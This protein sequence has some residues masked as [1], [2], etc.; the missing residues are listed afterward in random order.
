MKGLL[1]IKAVSIEPN[2]IV[3]GSPR[4]QVATERTVKKES[5]S[6]ALK[7]LR[8]RGAVHLSGDGCR[9][10]WVPAVPL[11]PGHYTLLVDE[12]E[13]PKG[14]PITERFSVPFTV[15]QSQSK[16]PSNLIIEGMQRLKIGPLQ[17]TKL[18]VFERPAGRY[19]ELIKA[20]DRSSGSPRHL[21]FNE[22]GNR[23]D[24]ER[25]IMEQMQRR[26]RRYG[27]LS[28]E[29][30][31]AIKASKESVPVSIWF[32]PSSM[33]A[34]SALTALK[35]QAF[36][37]RPKQVTAMLRA[38][39]SRAATIAS[40]IRDLGGRNVLPSRLAPVVHADLAPPEI[41]RLSGMEEITGIFLRETKGIPDLDDSIEI[42][43]SDDVHDLGQKGS[44][45]RVAVW[46]EGPDNT[47]NLSIKGQFDTSASA[48]TSSHSRLVHAVI[49]NTQASAKGHAPAC[50]LYSANSY[51]NDALDWA[52]ETPECTVINQSFHRDSEQTSDSLSSDDIYKD[53]LILHWPFPTILQAA[54][55]D[56]NPGVEYVNHKGYNSLTVGNHND[57]ASSMSGTS[58]YRNPSSN[59]SD[60]ELPEISANGVGVTAVGI[61]N[62]GTSFASP[63]VAGIAALIQGTNTLLKRWPEG[64]RAILLAGAKRNIQGQTWWQDVVADVDA[65]D[66]SGSADALES[67]FI[68][69][70]RRSRNSAGTRRGWDVGTMRSGDFNDNGLSTFSYRITIPASPV[71]S[72]LGPRHV[73]VALAWNSQVKTLDELFPSWFPMPEVPIT[74]QLTLD[75]DLKVF[76]SNGNLVGYSGSWDNSY[77]IAEF[78]GKP[79]QT[80]DI[81]I[82]R[83]SGTYESWYGIAW[84]VTGGISLTMLESAR[85][86][87]SN[88]S[89]ELNRLVR[90]PARTRLYTP[91]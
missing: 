10:T 15:V 43:N 39:A 57:D 88:P 12:M 5:A 33:P 74:S 1:G 48:P 11:G 24:G 9:L 49:K 86:A 65:A 58:V 42:H 16:V 79:G 2:E 4:I 91:R 80:Y 6:G 36:N 77:E 47:S 76:D 14:N 63:A 30:D 18:S 82:R 50:N 28:P 60:R 84:T 17:T 44:G 75:L 64:C 46:E 67:Y 7:V 54:G 52:L 62:S 68:T 40:R 38:T 85:L 32:R 26:V 3:I 20:R 61:T 55:N 87:R 8:T 31:A 27:K 25:L 45:I 90:R 83:W 89:V 69:K 71:F 35:N 22:T 56:S 78:E 81:K 21:A 53:W 34:Q 73:K 66:G 29:L 41:L 70:N 51:D 37:R 59:H 13:D 23:V 19:V 72:F